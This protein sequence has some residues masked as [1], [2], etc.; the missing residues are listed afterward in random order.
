MT[1]LD[2]V[3]IERPPCALLGLSEEVATSFQNH[4]FGWIWREAGPVLLDPVVRVLPTQDDLIAA[5]VV[6][7]E[8]VAFGVIVPVSPEPAARAASSERSRW[9]AR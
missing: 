4:V 9:A 1:Q 5:G 6:Q 8:V 7:N 3:L 2:L